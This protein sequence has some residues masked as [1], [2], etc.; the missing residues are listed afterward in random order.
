MIGSAQTDGLVTD[1]AEFAVLCERLAATSSRLERTQLVADFLRRLTP[2]E[3]EVATRWLIGRAFPEAQGR[4]MA[5]SG[6]AVWEALAWTGADVKAAAWAGAEDFGELVRQVMTSPVAAHQM[7]T[8]GDVATTFTAIAAA[9]GLGSR[10]QRITLLADL[11]QRATPLEAKYIAKIVVGEM[12]HGVQEGIV[13]DAIAALSGIDGAAVRRAQQALGDIGRLA[14]TAKTQGAAGLAAIAV[15]LFRPIK[16]M[17]AQTA[18]NVATAFTAL[19]GRLALEWKLDGARVQIHKQGERVQ[20]FSRRLQ[21]ITASLPEIV[22]RVAREARADTAIFEGEVIPVADGRPLPFQELMRRFRRV[23]DV[24][25][26]ATLVPVRL[27]LFDVLLLEQQLLLDTPAAARWEALQQARGD[28]DCVARIIPA[29]VAEG[30]RFY[31][32]AVASGYEGVMAKALDA[33]YTPGV[34]G[35]GWLKIKK[36]VTLDLVVI[37]ADWGYGRRHGWLSNYHL[38][39]RDAS[40]GEFVP[41]G[42]TFKGLTDAEFQAMTERLLRLKVDARGGTVFVRPEVVVEVRFTDIQKSPQYACG[43]ALRF[44]RIFRIRD[45]KRA[46]DADTVSTLRALYAQA[47]P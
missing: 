30:Q 47:N 11:L 2:P 4:R 42:K 12:R 37:A 21:D 1:F 22:E 8:L 14:G 16:P 35:K 44:A 20:L 25:E 33:G 29:D 24:S 19:E 28:L 23:R 31:E 43:L 38:A 45:D 36:I 32:A 10:K 9:A 39:A 13:L 26:T 15:Q 17:L 6:R 41:V 46:Q 40:T 7:L 3:A 18:A 34:R 5:L 27:Y